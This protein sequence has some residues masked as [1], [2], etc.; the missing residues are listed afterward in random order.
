M[1]TKE[2]V[3]CGHIQKDHHMDIK[4]DRTRV[5]PKRYCSAPMCSCIDFVEPIDL[6]F[7]D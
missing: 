6:E 7:E 4:P 2:C 1:P 3:R 5:G